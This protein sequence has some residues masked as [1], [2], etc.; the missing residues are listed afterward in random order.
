MKR[1]TIRLLV[2]SL[3]IPML[4]S[5]GA[6]AQS[7]TTF[8]LEPLA[9][10][11]TVSVGF[12]SGSGHS[13][14]FYIAEQ[15]GFFDELN[16]DIEYQSFI[17]GPAMMEANAS[18]DIADVGGPGVLVGQLGYDV[19]MVGVCDYEE[20][21]ALFVRNDSPILAAGKGALAD[22]PEVYG[23]TDTWKGTKWL[24][25]VGTNL[26]MTLAAALKG[27]GLGTPDI[28]SVNMDVSSALTAFKGGEADG[29]AVWNAVAFAAEDAGFVRVGDAGKL[30]VVSTC[31]LVA[32]KDALENKRDLIKK[33][34]QVY[35]L[36]WQWCN[37]SEENMEKAIAYYV[38]SCETEGVV[39]DESICRRALEY[40]RCPSMKEAIAVMTET[41]ADKK[42]L[43]TGRELLRAE[44][45]L[46]ETLDFFIEQGKY[47]ADDRLKVLDNHLVDSSIASEALA[48][49]EA[50][51]IE[52][53]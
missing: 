35:Y 11:Q 22:Y 21:L 26:H 48:D 15:E 27:F 51:G 23:N 33:V 49:F 28:E 2:V 52:I 38:D 12:F 6:L 41:E 39:S 13:I 5:A 3:V 44:N 18:W 1:W 8:G 32:T 30:G 46:L 31:G 45:N 20:N 40:F 53:K 47:T 10:R 9:Q 7:S 37:E 34:W 42:G 36:T 17:N 4:F 50:R 14:P 19:R 29:L 43:Y 24:Y 16:I 25:P